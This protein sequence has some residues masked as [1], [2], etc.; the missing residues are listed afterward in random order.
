MLRSYQGVAPRLGA[1]V[2]VDQQGSVIG[3]V[4]LGDDASVW[5]MAVL[6]GDVNR[7]VVGARSNVQDGAVLHVTHDGPFS[8]G[9][10]PLL[11]GDDVTVGHLA[12]LHA[13]TIGNRVLIGMHA[14]VLDQAVIEDEVLL[15]AGSVVP[16]GKRL[17]SGW[18]YRGSPAAPARALTPREIEQLHYSAA[19]YVR[20][21]DRYLGEVRA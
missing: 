18:L 8:P 17:Q 3:D 9:G 14:T 19:H 15:A 13:C 20:L 10:V 12:M 11:I 21:K 4:A 7:I 6:R 1:R 5:P 16:P 2:Y